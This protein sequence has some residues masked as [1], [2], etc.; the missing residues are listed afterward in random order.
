VAISTSYYP[1]G[2]DAGD[3]ITKLST[4]I[5]VDMASNILKEFWPDV[6]RKLQR[7]HKTTSRTEP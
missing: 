6:H 7:T 4:Q 1:S 3:A 2:R 5:G